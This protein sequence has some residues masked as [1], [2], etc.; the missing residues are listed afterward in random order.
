MNP[1][2]SGYATRYNVRC[3]DNRIIMHGA[4]S[5][6]DGKKVPLVYNHRHGSIKDVL[7]YAILHERQDGVYSDCYLNETDAGKTAKAVLQ[8]GDIGSLSIFANQLVEVGPQVKKGNIRE[9]SLV[10]AGANP[11]ATIDAYPGLIVHGIMTEDEEA[12]YIDCNDPV[13]MSDAIQH[14][15]SEDSE[16][17]EPT[18]KD[19][20]DNETDNERVFNSLNEEQK[21]LLYEMIGLAIDSVKNASD[22]EDDSVT[23]E[24]SMKHSIFD[25]ETEE[26]VGGA[27]SAADE[28]AIFA[29]IETYGSLK[30]ACL[31]HSVTDI[32]YNFDEPHKLNNPPS[33]ISRDMDWVSYVM[34]KVHRTPFAN[35]KSLF[36]DITGDDARALGYIKGNLKK[37][38]VFSMLKRT[39]GP[40]TVYKKQKIDRDDLID[41]VDF[42]MAAFIKSEMR[43]MLNEE[44]ARAFLV[45]DGRLASSDDKI[46]EGN[47]RPIAKEE[48]LY[49]VNASVS[50]TTDDE[51]AKNFIRA[52]IMARK[53]YKGSGNPDL[54]T[55][56]EMLIK[57]LLLTDLNGRDMY[58]DQT[59]LAKK[60]RVNN[61]ITV[62]VMEGAKD[63]SGN[64][65]YGIIVNL[66]D[67]NVGAD[68]GGAV[69]MFEDFDIDYNKQ[70]YLIETRCSGALVVPYSAIILSKGTTTGSSAD[71]P[72]THPTK[73]TTPATPPSGGTNSET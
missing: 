8:H 72:P 26:V 27:L 67:Y 38:E 16:A 25:N 36:A 39:T 32:E 29:D 22:D 31:A 20:N 44:L 71:F 37:E 2:F 7:G 46:K 9:L 49:I 40:T 34:G 48:A 66:K 51:I 55:T 54:F 52:S 3:D 35:I 30:K 43:M 62:P 5:S 50:G 13:V 1:D 15:A 4:F 63:G 28:A 65:I 60:L 41:I 11:G 68:R 21:N 61:I 12:Y 6:C 53:D 59:Q 64:P 23:E 45:G 69:Q 10:L 70:K 19:E 42:D 24:E 73:P 17:N 58:T 33:L 57:M 47:I 14:A 18:P 56:E